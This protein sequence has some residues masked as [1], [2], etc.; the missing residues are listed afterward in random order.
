MRLF[1]ATLSVMAATP[2]A[3]R[4]D[5]VVRQPIPPAICQ[6][7]E[8]LDVVGPVLR[9]RTAYARLRPSLVTEQPTADPRVVH[10]TACL[11]VAIYDTPL[12]GPRPA[13]ACVP[14]SFDVEALDHGLRVLDIR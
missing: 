1:L 3:A 10:C 4:A 8:V 6:R 5:D 13:L 11:E 2:L 14:H 9:Q 7:Q 12:I